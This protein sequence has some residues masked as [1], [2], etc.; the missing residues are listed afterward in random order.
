MT[1]PTAAQ[2][3]SIAA[4]P[5]AHLAAIVASSPD[6]IISK[7]L[8]GTILSWNP[9]AERLYG[10]AA[11]EVVG[12]PISVLVPPDRRDELRGIVERLRRGERVEP[13]DTVRLRKDGR[14][15]DVSVTVS[16]VRNAEGRVVG[17][18]AIARDVTERRR[19]EEELRRRER[20]F[21]ALVEHAFD[22]IALSD[23][24]GTYTD[25]SPSVRRVLGYPPEEL[26]GL[27]GFALLHPEEV[28]TVGRA[29]GELL[30]RPGANS[31]IELRGRHKDG[32]WRWLEA[33]ATNLLDD[34]SVGA[35]VSN[36][37][38]V[39]ERKRAEEELATRARQQAAVADLGQQALAT[40]D[41]P[42]L[43]DASVA[44]VADTLDVEYAKVLELLPDGTALG[45][46]AGVG[47]QPGLVGRATVGAG[48]DSQAGYTLR[49]NEPVVVEDLRA[50]TRFTG[51]PL[52]HDHGVI[53]GLSVIIRG[54]AR[55]FGVLGA[56]TTARRTFT[57]D[58][59]HFLQAVAN[60]LAAAIARARAED[61]LERR[62]AER[63][64]ELRLLLDLTH[65]IAATLELHPV[66]CIV[67][68]RVRDVLDYTGAAI[69]V[70]DGDDDGLSLLRYQG[71]IPQHALAWRWHLCSHAHARE[72]V[73]TGRPV[74]IEDVSADTPLARSYRENA[75][76]D[77]GEVP[78]DVG[79]WMG[80]PLTLGERVTGMLAVEATQPGY[81]TAHHAELLG[82]VAN[83]AAIAVENARLYEQARGLAALEERQRL[84]R[85]LHDSVSQALYGIGLGARTARVLLDRDPAR[86]AEPLDYVVSL[87]E[88]GLTEM[89]ALIFELRPDALETEGLVALLDKQAAALRARHGLE[90]EADLGPEPGVPM[91]VKETLYRIAQ[92][93][94]HNTVKHAKASR[95]ALRLAHGPDG[96]ELEVGDD[97]VGF[98]PGGLFP[99]HLGLR[100]M[101]ERAARHGAALEVESA[102][103]QGS[104]TRVLIP[105]RR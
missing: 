56:H 70:L 69:L 45:L 11:E 21:R 43:L 23:A 36:V 71:P 60:V 27:N 28:E 94:L 8:D 37:R 101:R 39:T 6:A 105:A 66:A 38:D 40:G 13:Y 67:L 104:R 49:A 55:P 17:A 92:E 41:V 68:D 30:A 1:V 26:V 34:P 90:V 32:S 102:P 57:G 87:A 15:V 44:L 14:R 78:A 77:I 65:D 61:L 96:T 42:R 10:Y 95:V 85:E 48:L 50:E 99:G 84:A 24:E 86:A 73:R 25:V 88:A 5:E 29:L 20:R 62:V 7:S 18:A 51:P 59:A 46:R 83:Q 81:Y 91:P 9:G 12:R 58:D 22:V 31:T 89:R 80:V 33:T 63:T 19:A 2:T 72:V 52:L 79:T 100:S 47:W 93:A 35:I 97:G 98:D 3:A 74:I 103:G 75:L 53:S 54:G 76:R 64:R 16:P 82:A 4:E